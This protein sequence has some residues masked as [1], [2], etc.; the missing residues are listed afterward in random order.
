MSSKARVIE[1]MQQIVNVENKLN[2]T[3][4]AAMH[5]S[6]VDFKIC[7]KFLS[8]ANPIFI[9]GIKVFQDIEQFSTNDDMTK[10]FK[11]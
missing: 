8:Y 1:A 4:F 6:W 11:K 2:R 5:N 3:K 7:A 9:F 10:F